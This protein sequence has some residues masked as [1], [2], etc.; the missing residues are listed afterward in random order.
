M[1]PPLLEELEIISKC[2]GDGVSIIHTYPTP[3]F[4]EIIRINHLRLRASKYEPPLTE[5]FTDEANK[6]LGRIQTFSSEQWAESEPSAKSDWI[7]IGNIFQAAVALY[8]ISSLQ[9]LSILPLIPILRG[10]CN[11]HGHCLQVLLK[12]ALSS[13]STRNLMLWPLVVLGMEAVNGGAA[14]RTFVR[15]QLSELSRSIGTYV[16]LN[17]KEVLER[18]WAS[19]TTNW[20]AC[21]D[22]PYAFAT[23]TAVDVCQ[24]G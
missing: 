7:L 12:K 11:I 4:A 14:M 16:P 24:L 15:E 13:P 20:D 10:R 19:S 5:A 18:F 9:S 1:T 8:C 23:Q 22:R 2:F 17:A 3:L 6:I 21:F